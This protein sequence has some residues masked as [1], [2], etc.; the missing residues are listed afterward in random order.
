MAFGGKS[1]TKAEQARFDAIKQGGCMACMQRGIDLAGQGLIEVHH[2]LSGGRRIGHM[3]TV[4]L[5]CWHHR[6]AIFQFHT[7]KDMR[8]EYGPSL[9]E[10]SKPFHIEFGSDALLLDMQNQILEGNA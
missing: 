5:C 3:A 10:G 4:G 6:A 7:H 9:A 1:R 2:L 8:E